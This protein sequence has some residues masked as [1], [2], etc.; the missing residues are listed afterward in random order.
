METLETL[1]FRQRKK[2]GATMPFE[3]FHILENNFTGIKMLQ[4]LVMHDDWCI[5]TIERVF[6]GE[7]IY[8]D[9]IADGIV[10][11]KYVFVM[12]TND[13]S[14]KIGLKILHTQNRMDEVVII[15]LGSQIPY[16]STQAL[17]KGA[18]IIPVPGWDF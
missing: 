6:P 8:T 15:C 14:R 7:D 13:Y 5:K 4:L 10:N 16:Y 3:E 1:L 2:K 18:E 17:Y 11:Y 9:N 12:V